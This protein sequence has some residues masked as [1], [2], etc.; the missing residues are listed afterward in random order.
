MVVDVKGSW[1]TQHAKYRCVDRLWLRQ[2]EELVVEDV[3]RVGSGLLNVCKGENKIIELRISNCKSKERHS[4][5][6][7]KNRDE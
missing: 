2:E 5:G 6:S 3:E 4:I 1:Q 7:N